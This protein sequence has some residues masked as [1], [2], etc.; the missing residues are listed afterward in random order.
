MGGEKG[1]EGCLHVQ[2]E[3]VVV[4]V[5][6]VEVWEVEEA[7]EKGGEGGWNLGKKA[8]GK[9]VGEVGDLEGVIVS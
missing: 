6:G 5:D 8:T 4:E 9:D 7:S 3:S 1:D 2:A